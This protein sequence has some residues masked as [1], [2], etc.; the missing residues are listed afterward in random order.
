MRKPYLTA[1]SNVVRDGTQTIS[2]FRGLADFIK[3]NKLWEGVLKYTWLSKFLIVVGL[4]GSFS[5]IHFV[6]NYWSDSQTVIQINTAGFTS[7]LGGFFSE[8]YDLF[9]LGGLK[10]LILILMEVVIFH[11]ARRTL[12]VKTGETIDTSL[13]VFI[14]AQIRM[15]KVVFYSWLME[16]IM[17][18]IVV[19]VAF[20][21]LGLHSMDTIVTMLIQCYFLGFAVIDNYNEIYKMTIKQSVRYTMQYGTVAFLIG[22]VVYLIMLIPLAGTL[23]GPLLGAVVGTITMYELHQI[24]RNM[25]WVFIPKAKASKA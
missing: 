8:G 4:V 2:N 1:L 25:D 19:K 21:I 23:M 5:F 17:T 14:E 16:T 18:F 22:F 6:Y 9:V 10:Y 15:I 24:D 12:E 7:A 11:F 20:S 3:D 13:K